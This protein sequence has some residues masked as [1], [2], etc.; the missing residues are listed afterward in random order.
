MHVSEIRAVAFLDDGTAVIA[1]RFA[2]VSPHIELYQSKRGPIIA[3][4]LREPV[5]DDEGRLW[6]VLLA[7]N[8]TAAGDKQ[9]VAGYEPSAARMFSLSYFSVL[10]PD[11]PSVEECLADI[12]SNVVQKRL[13]ERFGVAVDGR[14]II[15]VDTSPAQ[16][17]RMIEA[18]HAD[19][20]A[21][22]TAAYAEFQHW[23]QNVKTFERLAKAVARGGGRWL[24]FIAI[25]VV[26]LAMLPTL[27]PQIM[28]MLH[29]LGLW[30][31]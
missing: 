11:K 10:C 18:L 9:A 16:V 28:Q 17:E 24:L 12:I 5:R 4:V 14:F 30:R 20:N 23:L 22:L 21:M 29:G 31:P 27:L 1:K 15:A 8:I 25:A 19:V 3:F 7:Q 6:R 2:V 26:I 13:G